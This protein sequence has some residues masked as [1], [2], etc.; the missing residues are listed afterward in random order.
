MKTIA[1]FKWAVNPDDALVRVDG[2]VNWGTAR[3]EV[4]DDDHAAIA[5][6]VEAADGGEVIGLTLAGGDTAFAAARGAERTVAVEGFP[7]PADSTAVAHALADAIKEIGDVNAVVIGDAE[8]DPAVS[9]LVAGLLG[10]PAIMAVDA[11]KPAENGLL[12]TQR[13]GTGTRDIQV[14]CPVLLDV[15]ARR[16]EEDKPGM[17]QVLAARKKPVDTVAIK[18]DQ[19]AFSSLGTRLPD[20]SPSCLFDGS[21]PAEAVDQLLKALKTEGIL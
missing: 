11:V 6:A 9:A 5:C 8:W 7:V 21:N 16:E 19:P 12:V 13:F 17:R 20:T 14:G 2:T 15:A 10:W 3:Q 18:D 4:G 1:I